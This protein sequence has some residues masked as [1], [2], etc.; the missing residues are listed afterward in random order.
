MSRGGSI[1]SDCNRQFNSHDKIGKKPC[2]SI[3]LFW[4]AAM[5]L[6]ACPGLLGSGL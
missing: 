3:G 4:P 2:L 5:F 1:F 6:L